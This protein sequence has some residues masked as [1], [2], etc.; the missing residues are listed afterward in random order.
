M[1][2]KNSP[3]NEC[4]NI[5]FFTRPELSVSLQNSKKKDLVIYDGPTFLDT[6]IKS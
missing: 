4:L 6:T 1:T 5:P 2:I 3:P